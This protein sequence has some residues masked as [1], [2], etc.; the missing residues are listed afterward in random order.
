MDRLSLS[1]VEA[2]TCA[3][4]M[5]VYFFLCVHIHG[6]TIFLAGDVC[7]KGEMTAQILADI[8]LG[9]NE[10][11]VGGVATEGEEPLVLHFVTCPTSLLFS[12]DSL[13]SL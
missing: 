7:L 4:Q 6:T 3:P 5:S 9:G 11:Y 2:S 12:R 8:P 13:S 1:S 10:V